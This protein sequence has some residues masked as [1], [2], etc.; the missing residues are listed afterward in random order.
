MPFFTVPV[1]GDSCLPVL[2][3]ALLEHEELGANVQALQALPLAV[4]HAAL[5]D[6]LQLHGSALPHY[7]LPPPRLGPVPFYGI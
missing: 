2:A 7:R 4:V 3:A 5:D 1:G 6:T